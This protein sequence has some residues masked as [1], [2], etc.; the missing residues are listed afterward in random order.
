MNDRND[1]IFAGAFF[2]F[3]LG[4]VTA[5]GFMYYGGNCRTMNEIA[6]AQLLESYNVK[7]Q[8]TLT[9]AYVPELDEEFSAMSYGF[10][11]EP[12]KFGP[13]QEAYKV[14][15]VQNEAIYR[16]YVRALSRITK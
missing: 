3:I 7:A 16:A 6:G 15:L 1:L 11:Y 4:I 8:A 12:E 14:L 2:G 5:V 9:V 10:P 13:N